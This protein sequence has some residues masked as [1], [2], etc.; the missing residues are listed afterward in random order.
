MRPQQVLY[1]HNLLAARR[2]RSACGA[3]A[4]PLAM[5]L[6]H[7]VPCYRDLLHRVP[8]HRES[9]SEAPCAAP[10]SLASAIKPAIVAV[11]C[12]QLLLACYA[13]VCRSRS[14]RHRRSGHLFGAPFSLR[15]SV[16]IHD[17][18][19][20]ERSDLFSRLQLNIF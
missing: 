4:A 13:V 19:I 8:R 6:H 10:V 11:P 20:E 17:P 2:R 16:S 18:K 5:P 7:R 14:R 3:G 12:R 15:R 9:L 1:S